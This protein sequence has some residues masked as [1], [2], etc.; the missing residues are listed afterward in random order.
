MIRMLPPPHHIVATKYFTALVKSTSMDPS[1]PER[2]VAYLRALETIDGL[3]IIKGKF[4]K[5][6]VGGAFVKVI[7]NNKNECNNMLY[8]DESRT[9]IKTNDTVLITKH[10]EKESDVNIATHIMFDCAQNTADCIVLL[11]NDTDL[12]TPLLFAKE[13]YNK[14]IGIISPNNEAHQ[15]FKSIATFVKKIRPSHL[16]Y[17]LFPEG[18]KTYNGV[19]RKPSTW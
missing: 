11:S 12:K 14:V 18:V 19:V 2:Q 17:C 1:K 13:K 15:D 10:E 7:S 8:E 5:V 4:K 9:K 3:E 6:R 16:R